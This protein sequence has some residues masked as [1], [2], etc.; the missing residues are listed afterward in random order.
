MKTVIEPER[1]VPVWGEYDVCVLG[2]SCTGVF[3]A[4]R[5]AQLGARTV[6]IE[7]Q[8]CFGGAATAGLVNIWHSLTDNA[9]KKQIISGLTQ[10]ILERLK[11]R[12]AVI[13]LEHTLRQND[14]NAYCLNTEELK[15]ELDTLVRECGV[16][17]M[18]HTFFAAPW[19]EDGILKAVFV[20]TKSGRRAVMASIFID[21]T[22]DADLCRA[23]GMAAYEP[24]VLQPP[25]YCA[26]IVGT[27][28]ILSTPRGF[29]LQACIAEHGTQF[30]LGPDWGWGT[31][32]PGFGDIRMHAETHVFGADCSEADTLT[33]S[34][35]EGRRQVRAVMDL[36]RHY[37]PGGK[38]TTL[39]DLAS[40]IGIRESW[41]IK[42]RHQITD[43]EL[44]YGVPFED[45]IGY[46]SYRVDIHH[47]GKAGITFRYL[48]GT[49]EVTDSSGQRAVRTKGMWRQPMEHDPTYYQIP[50][51]SLVPD[52]ELRNVL[53]CGRMIDAQKQ[54]YSALRVMVN[55]NQMGE[56]AGVASALALNEKDG[57]AGVHAADVRAALKR[58]GAVIL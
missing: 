9:R 28:K 53:M 52:G 33:K 41:H 31:E 10:E 25:T 2:A 29:D 21:A 54:A 11:T 45:A 43:D 40:T 37:A 8:N 39:I 12:D 14:C 46:G 51:R 22:G 17:P 24:D 15:I 19:V 44:L 5:A 6:L 3:A 38:E 27:G 50:F 49:E 4:V 30:G 57:V 42:S 13:D 36:I 55:L 58:M 56:A 20:E 48:D 47:N 16:T 26:K 18:L 32:I 23:L 7:K 34:E 35:M 1:Q